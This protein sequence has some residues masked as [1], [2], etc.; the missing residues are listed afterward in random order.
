M[1]DSAVEG[2]LEVLHENERARGVKSGPSLLAL[3]NFRN[4]ELLG[5]LL[6]NGSE[7]PTTSHAD[8]AEISLMLFL[9]PDMVRP[10]YREL[11]QSTSSRFLAASNSGNRADNPSGMGGF[12]SA[13]ASAAVGKAMLDYRTALM[14]ETIAQV[15]AKRPSGD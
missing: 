10:G 6:G 8:G 14:G 13:K 1:D 5:R 12:P 15:L 9:R 11:P 4:F 2:L 3:A 7:P